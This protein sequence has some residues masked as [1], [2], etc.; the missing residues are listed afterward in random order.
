MGPLGL[1]WIK[2]NEKQQINLKVLDFPYVFCKYSSR[3][4]QFWINKTLG[5]WHLSILCYN[6]N[7]TPAMIASDAHNILVEFDSKPI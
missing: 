1:Y 2:L 6:F 4:K 5:R 3:P 7:S